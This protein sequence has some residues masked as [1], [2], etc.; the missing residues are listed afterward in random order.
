LPPLRHGPQRSTLRQLNPQH[1]GASFPGDQWSWV[2]AAITNHSRRCGPPRSHWR[3]RSL[4]PGTPSRLT[5]SEPQN[6]V[7]EFAEARTMKC[8]L[9]RGP[10]CVTLRRLRSP[11]PIVASGTKAHMELPNRLTPQARSPNRIPKARYLSNQQFHQPGRMVLDALLGVG[12]RSTL[13][14]R[15]RNSD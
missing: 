4:R 6:P 10:L 2:P 7:E 13:S 15:K 14:S 3:S 1:P 11:A 5:L 9:R 12:I 8:R